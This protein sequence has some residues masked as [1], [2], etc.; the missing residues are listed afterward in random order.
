MTWQSLLLH[1]L[2]LFELDFLLCPI[3]AALLQLFGRFMRS[4]TIVRSIGVFGFKDCGFEERLRAGQFQ[5]MH[6]V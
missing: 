3:F 5:K 4:A 6:F 2:Y 1:T